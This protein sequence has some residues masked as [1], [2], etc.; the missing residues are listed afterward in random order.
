MLILT[1]SNMNYT[2]KNYRKISIV[3]AIA[4]A[5]AAMMIPGASLASTALADKGGKVSDSGN[6]QQSIS[7]S[8]SVSASNS[9]SGGSASADHNTQSN[10]AANVASVD[11]HNH[12]G[13]K[14]KDSGNV[15][16]AIGQS[17]SITATN[18]GTGGS[19]NADFNTQTNNAANIASVDIH[20]HGGTIKDSG[21]VAQLIAQA[22][23][24]NATNT[25]NGGSATADFNTQNNTATNFADIAIGNH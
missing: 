8:N 25:G 23:S 18:T 9:G 12:G 1:R 13:G 21:N 6:V 10:N 19:A 2:A 20:N 15:L 16:Q 11:I 3:A 14:I 5:I 22:N 24:I 4:I 7:Q 17:N